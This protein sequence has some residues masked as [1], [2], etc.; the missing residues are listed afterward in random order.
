M[1]K[2][3]ADLLYARKELARESIWDY[4]I[5]GL[6]GQPMKSRGPTGKSISQPLSE[7]NQ[8]KLLQTAWRKLELDLIATAIKADVTTETIH[9]A[10][11]EPRQLARSIL[12]ILETAKLADETGGE[13]ATVKAGAILRH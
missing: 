4:V 2:T 5:K 9:K 7:D 10:P 6:T 3:P 13:S 12:S 8:V 11:P 1:K